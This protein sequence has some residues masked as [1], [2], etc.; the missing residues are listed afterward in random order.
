MSLSNNPEVEKEL[1]KL[2]SHIEI[3]KASLEDEIEETIHQALADARDSLEL[4]REN[5]DPKVDKIIQ[6]KMRLLD[7][8]MENWKK[9]F[10]LAA[11][12]EV[13][14]SSADLSKKT[15]DCLDH[16]IEEKIVTL[17]DNLRNLIEE[18]VKL[19]FT[20]KFNQLKENV[21]SLK[22]KTLIALGVSAFTLLTTIVLKLIE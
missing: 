13:Q 18:E 12:E 11:K 15:L 22:N 17:K 16:V 2:R 9:D 20:P 4:I 6:D 14:S 19:A 21:S 10:R 5:I 8:K 7:N 1:N 3:R